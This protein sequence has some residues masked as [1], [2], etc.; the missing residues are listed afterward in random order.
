MGR[1]V[2]TKWEE[3]VICEARIV[4]CHFKENDQILKKAPVANV[5]GGKKI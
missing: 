1:Y 2:A 4:I 3:V 5:D